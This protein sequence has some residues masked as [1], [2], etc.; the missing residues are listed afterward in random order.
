M[1][2]LFEFLEYVNTQAVIF[3]LYQNAAEC[4]GFLTILARQTYM[5]NGTF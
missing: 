1:L 4:F 3:V 5:Q 2:K